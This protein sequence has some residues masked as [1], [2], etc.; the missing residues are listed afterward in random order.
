MSIQEKLY[1]V[2]VR[3]QRV[4]KSGNNT[5]SKYSY[6]TLADMLVPIRPY[7]DELKLTL[8]QS[9]EHIESGMLITDGGY[10]SKAS[11]Q[12]TTIL[13]DVETGESIEVKTPGFSSD[14][15]GD[16]ACYKAI[17][18][19]RKYGVSALFN[20]EWFSV[21]PEDP[22]Y[23]DKRFSTQAPGQAPVAQTRQS[24]FASRRS[25]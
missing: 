3:V 7:L 19:A 24:R 25:N 22:Q 20:L 2:Q 6:S 13:T 21:E 16:K 10:Y 4:E 1:Q 15:N 9:I 12:C 18:G 17:T 14:K 8:V 5:F 11:V 23:D